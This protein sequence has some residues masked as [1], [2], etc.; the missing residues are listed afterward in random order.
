MDRRLPKSLFELLQLWGHLYIGKSRPKF[1]E[2]VK[3]FIPAQ[4]DVL[5]RKNV[6]SLVEDFEDLGYT[7]NPNIDAETYLAAFLSCWLS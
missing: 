1:I 5:L 3:E 6:A 7:T 4:L 2:W